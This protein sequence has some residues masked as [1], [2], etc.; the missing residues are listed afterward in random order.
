MTKFNTQ[1]NREPTVCSS[2]VV[3]IRL[4]VCLFLPKIRGANLKLAAAVIVIG[5][6]VLVGENFSVNKLAYRK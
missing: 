1:A 5:W 4:L 2:L 6:I 3:K